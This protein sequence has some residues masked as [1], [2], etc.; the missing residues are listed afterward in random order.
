M[1]IIPAVDIKKGQ[2]V[3]LRQGK[4]DK[5]VY[6]DDPVKIA[7][8]WSS[9]GAKLI[10]V[11]D[12]DGAASGRIK[13]LRI[14]K[15]ILKSINTIVQFGGGVRTIRDIK[16]LLDLGVYRVVLGKG[17]IENPNFLQNAYRMFGEEIILSIDVEGAHMKTRG[18]QKTTKNKN[19]LVF[20][21]QLKDMGLKQIIYTD[22]L[23]DGTLSGPNIL[24]IRSLLKQTNIKVIASGGISSLEDISLLK[25]LEKEG[26]AGVII[27]KALYEKKFTLSEALKLA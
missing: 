10:H 8:N 23:K 13:N 18:W 14:L 12:L 2:V 21:R 26:L 1:L 15:R 7:Q 4:E 6:S 20:V 24:G 5:K 11:V 17:A 3:R 9:Q 25:I 27:G 16:N 19:V 22:I